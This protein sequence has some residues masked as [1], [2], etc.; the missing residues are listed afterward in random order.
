ML[1][2]VSPKDKV[3]LAKDLKKG[4]NNFSADCSKATVAS[5]LEAFHERW[6]ERNGKITKKVLNEGFSNDYLAHIDYPVDVRRMLYTT[7]SIENLNR[8]M[9]KVTKTKVTFGKESNMLVLI[10]SSTDFESNN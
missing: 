6:Q 5:N 8:K 7:N 1:N 3:T 10:Y 4:F 2:K 9:R